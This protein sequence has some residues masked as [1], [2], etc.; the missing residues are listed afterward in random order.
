MLVPLGSYPIKIQ[1][2]LLVEDILYVLLGINGK[3][4][5]V[6]HF[7]SEDHRWDKNIFNS[8]TTRGIVLRGLLV[9]RISPI[10]SAYS[11]FPICR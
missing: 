10:A 8:E 2:Q 11:V 1:E 3:Y 5:N 7:S 4:V 9:R 6:N